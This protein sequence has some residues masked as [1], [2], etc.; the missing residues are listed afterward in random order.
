MARTVA[1][2]QKQILDQLAADPILSVNLT[3]TSKRAIYTLWSFI[4][5]VS[6]SIFEQIIDVFTITIETMVAAAAPAT[7]SWLQAQVFNFQYSATVA[8]VIQLINFAPVYPVVDPSLRIVTRASVTS[9]L[10]NSVVVKVA[11]GVTPGALSG[12]EVDALQSY[13]NLIGAEGI[14][15]I[16]RSSAADRLYIQ[17]TIFYS[18]LYS[19]VIQANVITAIT[20]Y[21]SNLPFN[22]NLKISDIELAIRGVIGVT[23]VILQNVKAR[24]SLTALG[25]ATDLVLANA[26]I[27][28]LWPT[29][30][31][32]IIQEDTAANTFSDTLTFVPE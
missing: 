9:D 2:I 14:T 21:L 27:A 6:I 22:G 25:G 13:V 3:S 29:Q 4:V 5:A 1:E 30:A 24:A 16:V 17:A 7:S 19:S 11:K 28:R 31:G 32:Y 15:Y 18:G 26:T 12:P 23:D 20:T 10:S 8:Q